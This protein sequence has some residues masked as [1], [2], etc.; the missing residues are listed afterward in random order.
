M[1]LDFT[2]LTKDQIWGDDNGN[3][4]LDMM[5][6]YGTK[7]APTELATLL[8]ACR[9]DNERTSENDFTC[10]SWSTSR[11]PKDGHVRCIAYE[12][13]AYWDN[14][15]SRIASTRPALPP[16]E[17]SKISPQE[18]KTINGLRIVEYGEYPQEIVLGSTGAALEKL[19]SSGTL[20]PTGKNYTFDSIGLT[21]YSTPFKATTYPEY[22]Y[23]GEKYICVPGRPFRS[24]ISI[25]FTGEE[26]EKGKPYWVKVQPI[27]WLM[28]ESG[29]M[30]SKKCLFAGIQFDTEDPYKGDFSKTFLKH[31]L[32]TYFA[33]EIESSELKKQKQEVLT[34]LSAKLEEAIGSESVKTIEERLKLAE[35]GKKTQTTPE[36]L[37]EAAMIKRLKKARDILLKA[38]TEAQGKGEYELADAIVAMA[39]P[40]SARYAA[41]QNKIRYRHA[42]RKKGG[43]G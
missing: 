7:V 29:W 5:Q 37:H 19:H 8:G 6:R 12:G 9:S 43:R 20:R 28:D 40:Y 25:L 15:L 35:K 2:L 14:S 1:A 31:Y 3:G 18:T 39:R 24:H 34:G 26:I 4:Q 13:D 21:D 30:V 33:K 11:T 10:S 27:E 42:K 17:V 22:E 32:D 41:Q 36:R 23:A 16:S 38:H